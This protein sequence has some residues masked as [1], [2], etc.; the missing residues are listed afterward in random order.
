METSNHAMETSNH[1][2]ETNKDLSMDSSTQRPPEIA[3][4]QPSVSDRKLQ[5]NRR[6]ALRSTG[7]K[8]VRGKRNAARNA[9]KHGVLA[10]EVVITAGDGKENP[11]E[12][13][14]LVASLWKS[15]Q[16]VGAVEELLVQTIATCYWRKSRALR[17]ENGEI[18]R[19]LDNLRVDRE[20]AKADR[21]NLHL[22]SLDRWNAG[23]SPLQYKDAQWQVPSPHP[24]LILQDGQVAM[25]EHP[26]GLSYLRVY[27]E[28]AK[29]EMTSEGHISEHVRK[30]LSDAFMLWDWNFVYAM[31]LAPFQL[32]KAKSA[33]A[34]EPKNEV[35]DEQA[36][37]KRSSLIARID[38]QLKWICRLEELAIEREKLELD[39]EARS[40]CVP[41]ADAVDKFLRYEAQLDRQLHRAMDQLERL[42][43]RR[44]GER[45]PPPLNIN[46]GRR[47]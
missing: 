3:A 28:Y 34:E 12:F 38:Q 7:P 17:A 33:S 9:V 47:N 30:R 45:V 37:K 44:N 14:T 11:E 41:P 10:R 1:A 8:T 22:A 32:E 31:K 6:N 15:Y 39:A 2:T 19:R 25:R 16:P 36:E 23:D 13:Q 21:C 26:L 29:S 18:R 27:L 4:S 40:L 24:H 35:A 20:F 5:A 46:L 42:Q 43:L